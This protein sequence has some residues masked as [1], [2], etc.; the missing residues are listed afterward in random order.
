MAKSKGF[1]LATVAT[2]FFAVIGF[3][4]F[5]I[6]IGFLSSGD[7]QFLCYAIGVVLIAGLTSMMVVTGAMNLRP[8]KS[9]LAVGRKFKLR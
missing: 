6:V 5:L 4:A 8:T 7:F 1:S 9:E 2:L 3:G